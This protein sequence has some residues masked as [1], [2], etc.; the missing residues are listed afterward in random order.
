MQVDGM[1]IGMHL[2][3]K[4]I[5]KTVTH[6]KQFHQLY[7]TSEQMDANGFT[8]M[9][10]SLIIHSKLS[11]KEVVN[12]HPLTVFEIKVS[13]LAADLHELPAAR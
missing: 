3:P 13:V 9:L 1:V 11:Q 4:P 2:E 8:V 12:R 5:H 6:P 7:F 10:G